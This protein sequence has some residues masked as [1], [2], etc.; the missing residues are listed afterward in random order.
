MLKNVIVLLS[1]AIIFGCGGI[2]LDE[3]TESPDYIDGAIT[4]ALSPQADQ[5]A[6]DGI[7][8]VQQ[9]SIPTQATTKSCRCDLQHCPF[10][11]GHIATYINGRFYQCGCF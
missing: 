10:T 1:L 9:S 2:D 4:G 5:L 3:P 11:G 7:P 8:N 6:G